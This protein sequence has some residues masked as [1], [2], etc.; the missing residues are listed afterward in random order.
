MLVAGLCPE[1]GARGVG[2]EGYSV[3]LVGY[4]SPPGHDH[5]DNCMKKRYRCPTGHEWAVGLRRRCP[6]Q[7]CDWV[8][9]PTCFC[10][11]GEKVDEWP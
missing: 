10:H 9:R 7:D 4:S 5:D 11:P 2:Q 3:A 1:C 6:V 8:G